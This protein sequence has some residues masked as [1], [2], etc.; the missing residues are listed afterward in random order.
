MKILIQQGLQDWQA[1][2]SASFNSTAPGAASA[3]NIQGLVFTTGQ[4][5]IVHRGAD[6]GCTVYHWSDD[7][8]QAS[9]S[10]FLPLAPDAALE[11]FYNTRQTRQ[12]FAQPAAR[13]E[14]EA[15]GVPCAAWAELTK[16]PVKVVNLTEGLGARQSR[17]VVSWREWTEGVPL[18]HLDGKG[19]VKLPTTRGVTIFGPKLTG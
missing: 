15:L 8:G 1:L 7:E 13:A 11:G 4:L 16:P 14:L 17:R 18:T 12:F 2:E 9:I 5:S 19:K 3:I 10:T 6:N